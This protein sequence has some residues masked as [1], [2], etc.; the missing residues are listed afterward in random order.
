LAMQEFDV[1]HGGV[2]R[3]SRGAGRQQ[4]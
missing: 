3:G 2:L 1:G 4:C